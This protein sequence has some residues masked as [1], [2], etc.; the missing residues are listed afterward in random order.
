[1]T[2]AETV[3]LLAYAGNIDSRVRRKADADTEMQAR[4]WHA[5]L[6]DVA[7]A[8]AE[9]AITAHYRRPDPQPILP[10]DIRAYCVAR[11]NERAEARQ[12]QAL[13]GPDLVPM[14][15]QVREQLR[16]IRENWSA[17]IRMNTPD[18][19]RSAPRRSGHAE[20]DADRAARGRAVTVCFRCACDIPAPAGWNPRDREAPPVYCDPCTAAPNRQEAA[21]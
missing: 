18:R 1:M 13:T 14:P 21:S 16:Q 7:P 12:M 2:P 8:D 15:E 19:D 5:V 9:V 20:T 17:P 10:G 3:L 6:G 4:A 11:A